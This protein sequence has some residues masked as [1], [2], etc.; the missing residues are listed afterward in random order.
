MFNNLFSSEIELIH[1][2][3]GK[4]NNLKFKKTVNI[5]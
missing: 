3:K 5:N 2:K 4:N 1:L